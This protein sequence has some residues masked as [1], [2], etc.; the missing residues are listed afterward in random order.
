MVYFFSRVGLE[1]L[2]RQ[3]WLCVKRHIICSIHHLCNTN[4]VYK[5]FMYGKIFLRLNFIQ[6]NST[7]GCCKTWALPGDVRSHSSRGRHRVQKWEWVSVSHI[8]SNKSLHS[9]VS[10]TF[11]SWHKIDE[12]NQSWRH[13]QE[14]ITLM[15]SKLSITG[16]VY[17]C[18][19]IRV[20]KSPARPK[21][22]VGACVT[23]ELVTIQ[24]IKRTNC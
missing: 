1:V 10:N 14:T 21:R 15:Q 18:G 3:L 11:S 8:P 7:D 19:N 23:V 17:Y 22:T 13:N 16:N 12:C 5:I 20:A 9:V 24:K 4:S 6:G 2:N